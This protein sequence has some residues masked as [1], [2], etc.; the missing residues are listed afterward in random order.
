MFKIYE[1]PY[2][3]HSTEDGTHSEPKVLEEFYQGKK[4]I[5]IQSSSKMNKNQVSIHILVQ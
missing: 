3:L 1:D 2:T 4:N 5:D